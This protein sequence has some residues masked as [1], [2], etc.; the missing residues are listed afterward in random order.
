MTLGLQKSLFKLLNVVDVT[1][2]SAFQFQF[3]N[4]PSAL[5]VNSED[6]FEPSL[7][8]ASANV[9][10]YFTLQFLKIRLGTREKEDN[11]PPLC[12]AC[13]K[14]TNQKPRKKLLTITAILT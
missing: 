7:H 13:K 5:N 11:S 9:Q 14:P 3:S 1:T 2:T 12:L 6:I 10:V 4:V 8:T